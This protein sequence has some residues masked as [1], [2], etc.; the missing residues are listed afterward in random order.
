MMPWGTMPWGVEVQCDRR[1][2]DKRNQHLE[3]DLF[4]TAMR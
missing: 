2:L 1:W 3:I 4:E